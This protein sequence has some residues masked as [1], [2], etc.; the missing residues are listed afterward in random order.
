M[1]T[2]IAGS[3]VATFAATALVS[4]Y[5][6]ASSAA[7][8]AAAR[9]QPAY[10]QQLVTVE[11]C[12]RRERAPE[13]TAR[14]LAAD[15]ETS[16]IFVLAEAQLRSRIDTKPG[17]DPE[18]ADDRVLGPAGIQ[19]ERVGL[20]VDGVSDSDPRQAKEPAS[21]AVEGAPTPAADRYVV[22]GLPDARLK[23]F[24]GQRVVMTGQF[25]PPAAATEPSGDP[26]A[27]VGTSGADRWPANLP[28]FRATSVKP[29]PGV[30]VPK[31]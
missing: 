17:T 30:C 9:P 22:L 14:E 2:Q 1:R 20:P 31:P 24:A 5:A 29:V 13:E 27:P 21:P 23:P 6:V 19:S 10:E 11:G 4:A 8:Q 7:Q 3:I 18:A 25:D 16:A 15:P 26:A 28:Q 12:L